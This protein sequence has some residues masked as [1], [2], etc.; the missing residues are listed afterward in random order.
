MTHVASLKK[1][2]IKRFQAW[3][4]ERGAEVL[5]TTNQWEVIR[6]RANGVIQIIYRNQADNWQ[7]VNGAETALDAFMKNGSWH[8]VGGKS[9]TRTPRMVMALIQ[10]DGVGC[11]YCSIDMAIEEMSIEHLVPVAHGGPN[12]MSN[13]ALAHKTCNAQAGC[14]SVA[15]KVRLRDRLR[16]PKSEAA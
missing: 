16:Q 13:L 7:A 11:F 10:R 15:E 3:L 12:H 8:A 2:D 6:F 1:S 4:L 5:A 14:M 9:R